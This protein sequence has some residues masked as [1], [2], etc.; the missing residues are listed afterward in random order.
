[1]IEEKPE[2]RLACGQALE[3]LNTDRKQLRY[4]HTSNSGDVLTE[5]EE[6]SY[7]RDQLKKRG[8]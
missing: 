4:E 2:I 1:L 7:L 6:H 3:F 5:Y 8:F